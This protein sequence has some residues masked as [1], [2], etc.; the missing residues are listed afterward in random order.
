MK[1]GI[2]EFYAKKTQRAAEKP[3]VK[4]CAALWG[5]VKQSA[6]IK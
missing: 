3:F 2:T 6:Q 1:N 4:L 5:S